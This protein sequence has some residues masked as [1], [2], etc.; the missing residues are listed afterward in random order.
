MI[1]FSTEFFLVNA[2]RIHKTAKIKQQLDLILF[3]ICVM[4]KGCVR[5]TYIKISD[6]LHQS[7]AR[8]YE[9]LRICV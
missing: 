1:D 8:I 4:T 7:I 2:C 3:W 9:L 5:Q 6:A